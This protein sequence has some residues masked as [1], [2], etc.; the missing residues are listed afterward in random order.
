M[1][2][3]QCDHLRIKWTIRNVDRAVGARLSG[4]I[5]LRHGAAGLPQ[6]SLHL[7]FH[8]QAGKASGPSWPPA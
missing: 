1:L 8:G 2:A 6:D 4:S 3:G 7:H 5:V